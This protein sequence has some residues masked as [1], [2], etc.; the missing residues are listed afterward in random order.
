MKNFN[1]ISDF[2][3][4]MHYSSR[5]MI[6]YGGSFAKILGNLIEV[7]DFSNL[8]K[9]YNVWKD[10]IEEYYELYEKMDK[11]ESENG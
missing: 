5:A 11:K 2:Y 10:L 8:N 6:K 4:Y 1:D 3:N 9:I 7:S